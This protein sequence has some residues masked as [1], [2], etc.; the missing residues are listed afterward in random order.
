V[1]DWDSFFFGFFV[2]V[3]VTWTLLLVRDR[4]H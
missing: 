4:H 1:I 2:A 3:V